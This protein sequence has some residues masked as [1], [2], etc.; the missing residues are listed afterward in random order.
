[1]QRSRHQRGSYLDFL[2]RC[3]EVNQSS[4]FILQSQPISFNQSVVDVKSETLCFFL[5]GDKSSRLCMYTT[6]RL[7]TWSLQPAL[8]ST[9]AWPMT[10]FQP[11]YIAPVNDVFEHN[12]LCRWALGL[13]ASGQPNLDNFDNYKWLFSQILCHKTKKWGSHLR[14]KATDVNNAFW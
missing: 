8:T 5:K 2:H 10:A 11:S 9:T 1:M 4:V 3:D 14:R 6:A 12:V 13:R 7:S